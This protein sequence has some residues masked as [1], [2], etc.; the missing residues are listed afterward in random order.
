[1]HTFLLILVTVVWGSTFVII[2]DTVSSVN[3]FFIV[4]TRCLLAALPI[5]I[6]QTIKKPKSLYSKAV[7]IRGG[8]L[9]I[10]LAAT[11][12][13]QTIGLQYTSTGHSAFITGS[14][15]VLVPII[16]LLV[17]RERLILPDIISIF[18]ILIG[19]FLLTYDV[20]TQINIGDLITLITAVSCAVHIVIS[21]RFVK[22][23]DAASIITWQFVGAGLV[24]FLG[25]L[26]SGASGVSLTVKSTG[27]IIYLGFLGTFFCYFITVWVQQYVSSVL[28]VL[29]FSLEPVFAAF[30]GFLILR[31]TLNGSE[32]AG[33]FLVLGG[34]LLYQLCRKNLKESSAYS[35]K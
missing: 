5:F 18:I 34:V 35:K 20:K 27:A 15:V 4:F 21:G 11:Y 8:I 29:V 1:M 6:L 33:A 23:T 24:S 19:L 30:F 2:K 31:E 7:M 26:A 3:P 28:V 22:T 13:T 14:S 17:F 10:L 16:L 12:I 32:S 25:F 9:G